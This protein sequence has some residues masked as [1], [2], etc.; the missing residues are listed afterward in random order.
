MRHCFQLIVLITLSFYLFP[1]YLRADDG[2]S[3][4]FY[5]KQVRPVLVKH[6]YE[7]HSGTKAGGGLSLE[8]AS[9]WLKGGESGA[10]VVAHEPE[11]SLL[12]EAVRYKSL[13]MPPLEAGGKL[14]E[15]TIATLTTWIKNGASAPKDSTIKVGGMRRE[16]AEKW[17]SFQPLQPFKRELTSELIDS[18]IESGW[19]Q[20]GLKPSQPAD[21]RTLIRRVTYDLTGLPPTQEQIAEFLNDQSEH[22]FAN[23]VD[24]LLESPQYGVHWGRR[25]LDLVRYA[26]TAGENTDRPLP[27]AW[28]YRNWVFDAWNQNMPLDQFARMQI[29]GDLLSISK[30]K[31]HQPEG[32]IATGYL[33]IARRFGHNID[34]DMHLTYEDV[35][36][37]LGKT[38]LG[39]TL[40]CARCHDHKYDPVSQEDYY[41]LY[42]AFESS[43]FS[44][45]GC[46]PIGQPR[47]LIPLIES[48]RYDEIQQQYETSLEQYNQS[49]N[50]RKMHSDHLAALQEKSATLLASD[51]VGEGESKQITSNESSDP[52]EISMRKGE[53]LQL[54]VLPNA[55]HGADT[56][57][58]EL[59]IE[60]IS[61]SAAKWHSDELIPRFS[62]QN[63]AIGSRGA[64]W[65]LLDLSESPRLLANYQ[66]GISNQP[67]LIS[68]TNAELPSAMVNQSEQSVAVWTTLPS[69]SL[70]LHPGPNQNVAITWTCPKDDTYTI[71]GLVNDSHPAGLDG[72]SYRLQHFDDP[73][74]GPGL[75]QLDEITRAEIHD[76]PDPPEIPVAYGVVEGEIK[77]SMLQERGDPEQL[78]QPITRHWLTVFGGKTL[79]SPASSGRLEMA[80]EIV[81]NP[82]FSRTFVNRLWQWHFGQGLVTT[83]N[84]FGFRGSQP[85]HPI[86]LEQLA[87]HF[88]SGGYRIKEMHRLLVNT[89]T[90]QRDSLNVKN[91]EKDPD[92][93]WLSGFT[94]RR[95]TAEEI[96]DSLLMASGEI[97]LD[98]G[99][100]H[101]FPPEKDWNYSQHNPFNAVYSNARRSAFMMVQRQRRHPYLALF[102]GPDPNASTPARQSTTVPVQSLY[103]LN[104]PFFHHHAAA[105][106]NKFTD[107]KKSE[108]RLVLMYQ[109]LFGRDPDPDEILLFLDYLETQNQSHSEV[110]S[111][112]A[113]TMLSS[114]EFLYID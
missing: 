89:R 40:A 103:F 87:A 101:P 4:E 1:V 59:S 42:G 63:S 69:R 44:F 49:A 37:N 51:Q 114:N 17:W 84:D 107:T 70:F 8:D 83:P 53:V 34:H 82:L 108:D 94:R 92:N 29:A 54:T 16:Q 52:I 64:T 113:R 105:F 57:R 22:A 30:S 50:A 38:F 62:E 68:F 2:E 46:E 39:L 25:W 13:E 6:C 58:I 80:D 21:K 79:D 41:A 20:Q 97:D 77:N 91:L 111:S 76:P 78:G 56:T 98:F 104:D 95:L 75:M 55:N 33:A 14:N 73:D 28:R 67:S 65:C 32:I 109:K 31:P 19:T 85:T 93:H 12:I 36:D 110:W 5:E 66:A 26:D 100:A 9:G 96:R 10:A 24:R 102:D 11:S 99:E 47:D 90:Y 60:S 18:D 88:V 86:L 3:F 72:V 43:K 27:H 48:E 74:L 106:A 15:E 71:F 7:C 61:D 81:R 23:L 112:I 45:P 35:I